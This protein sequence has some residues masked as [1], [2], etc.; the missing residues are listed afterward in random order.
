MALQFVLAI[1][2][3]SVASHGFARQTQ[4][5]PPS[6]EQKTPALIRSVEGPDLYRA[7]CASCHGLDARG[8]GPAAASMKVKVPD[9]TLLAK[10]HRNEF[11]AD[12]VR[13]V[14]QSGLLVSAH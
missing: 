9:L 14:I 2:F 13:Q 10:N 11:P 3:V 7:Y 4:N 6:S 1:V 8:T 5:P 12:Y